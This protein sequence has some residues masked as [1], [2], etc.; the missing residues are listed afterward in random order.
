M[1]IIKVKINLNL[2]STSHC[3]LCDQAVVLL[4]NVP[5]QFDIHWLNIEITDDSSLLE[6]YG[7]KIPV[8]KRM[9]TNNEISW[10]FT[11]EDIEKLLSS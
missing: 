2:Y 10:P 3:H 5:N 7:F 9:D 11:S 6:R 4:R 8:L 1:G